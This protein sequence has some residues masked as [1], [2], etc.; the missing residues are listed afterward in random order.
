[1]LAIYKR[2]LKSYFHSFIGLLFI[3]VTLFFLGLYFTVYNLVYGYPY[4]AYAISSCVIMFLISVPVLSMKIF[5]EERKNKTDQLILTAPVSIGKIV[6]GKYLALV[7]I[8]AIPTIIICIYPIIMQQFGVVPMGEAYIAILAFFLYGA[9]CIAIGMLVSALT[10]SQVIAAVLGFIILFLG[11]LMSSISSLISSTG[12]LLTKILGCFDLYTPFNNLLGGTL[13]IS[14]LVYFLSIIV[15][16]LFLTSQSIQKRRYSVSVKSFSTGAYSTGMI[17]VVAAITVFVN[18]IVSEMPSTWTAIDMTTEQLYSITDQTK[19]FVNAM[20]ED[21]TIYVCVNEK[22]QDATLGQTLERYEDISDHIT[23]E[24]VDPTVNPKFHTQYTSESITTNSLI[25]VSDRRSK[26]VDYSSIYESSMDYTTYTSTTTGYDG[27]GQI[28]SA[29]DYV[30]S[31][32]MPKVYITEGHGE[33]SLSTSFNSA[34]TKENVEYETIN[35]MNYDTIPEDAACLIINAPVSDFSA[36]DTDKVLTYLEN[37]GKVIAITGY[38]DQAMSNFD[39]ILSYMELSIADGLVV[40]E[41]ANYYYQNPFYILPEVSSTTYTSGVY[42]NYY[43]FAPYAQGIIIENPDSEEISY[44]TILGTSDSAF[45]KVNITSDGDYSKAEGDVDGPFAI[46]VEAVKTVEAGEAVLVVY[47]CEQLF[48]DSAD[49]M[50]SG[51]NLMV[52]TNTISSFINNEVS[53]SI[54][55]KSYDVSSLTLTQSNVVT[56][57][58]L[59]AVI[60]PLFCLILGFVIWFGRRRR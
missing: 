2:E 39:E 38:T 3:G 24:Y 16:A 40:E 20:T 48:T 41:D 54:P 36:D 5:A 53:V 4:F 21:V 18:I 27:E 33:Y 52:F 19:T 47:S 1:M 8:F 12:N 25:F 13:N 32:D 55:V 29:L 17:A 35:I 42:G 22:A 37:G 14:S 6:L 43:V 51:A 15:L 11:Y 58:L 28:T 44:S 9:T 10:E 23:V 57:G 30:T 26:V 7:T 34:L 46:G 60:L 31:D 49:Q 50:V 45:S 56:I 59:A